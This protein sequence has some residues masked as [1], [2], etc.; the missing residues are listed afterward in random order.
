[1][2]S[3]GRRNKSR[4]ATLLEVGPGIGAAAGILITAQHAATHKPAPVRCNTHLAAPC[5]GQAT[6]HTFETYAIAAGLG[7]VIGLA[8]VTMILIAW[9]AMLRTPA[10]S[11]R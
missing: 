4:A 10:A 1:M 3:A 11:Q 6:T 8:L 9:R 5:I 2:A 7:A